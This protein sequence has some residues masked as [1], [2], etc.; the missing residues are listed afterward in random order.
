MLRLWLQPFL[1]VLARDM[2]VLLLLLL[3]HSN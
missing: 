1:F 2:A 3:H